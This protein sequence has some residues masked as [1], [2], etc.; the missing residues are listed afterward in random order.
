MYFIET[1]KANLEHIKK[2]HGILF[3]DFVRKCYGV[4]AA[5]GIRRHV[6][7][8]KDS[9]SLMRLLDQ[10]LKSADQFTYTFYLQQFPAEK[11]KW[12]WQRS[13]FASFSENLH[14]FSAAMISDDIE[15]IKTIAGKVSNFTDRAIAH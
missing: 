15:T 11:D 5:T 12:E 4:H 3:C 9:I 10:L 8:E 13:T 6:K 7:N 1:V 2:N 14:T